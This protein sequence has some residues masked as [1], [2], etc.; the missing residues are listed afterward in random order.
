MKVV[1]PI[2]NRTGCGQV[3]GEVVVEN[4]ELLLRHV[5][6]RGMAGR[7]LREAELWEYGTASR[8]PREGPPPPG[9]RVFKQRV[10]VAL[11]DPRPGRARSERQGA[12]QADHFVWACRSCNRILMFD[13]SGLAEALD[14]F[15]RT[16]KPQ[17]CNVAY[18]RGPQ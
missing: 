4:G 18:P 2:C 12:M 7:T 14:A 8:A 10:E 11:H 9:G 3:A 17:P 5:D 6:V 1:R 16:G 15:D 13:P